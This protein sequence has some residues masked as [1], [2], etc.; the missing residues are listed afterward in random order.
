MNERKRT[1]M[2]YVTEKGIVERKRKKG[3]RGK[4]SKEEKRGVRK[5]IK[6]KIG[7]M[8]ENCDIKR[9]ETRE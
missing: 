8:E 7:E 2:K 3:E 9:G 4:K 6:K 1:H 5:E